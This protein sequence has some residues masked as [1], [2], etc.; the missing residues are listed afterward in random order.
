[1]ALSQRTRPYEVLIR[2][3]PDGIETAHVQYIEEVLNDDKVIA[4][5]EKAPIPLDMAGPDFGQIVT[6]IN[7][8]ALA[9]ISALQARVDE[10]EA[11][12]V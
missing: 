9:Q 7:Q 4:A 2:L 10:L 6:L 1:M 12:A 3:S 5:A 8:T 11:E